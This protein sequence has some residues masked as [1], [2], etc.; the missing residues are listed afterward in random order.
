MNAQQCLMPGGNSKQ[1]QPTQN[2]SKNSSQVLFTSALSGFY[3][4]D[5]EGTT[6]PPVGWQVIDALNPA[7]SWQTSTQTPYNGTKSAFI[8]YDMTN[9]PGEDLLILPKF[10]V[11]TLDSFSFWLALQDT[12]WVPDSTIILVSTTDSALSSFT[13]VIATL[14]EGD[15]YPAV[16]SVY[17]YFSY[18]LSAFAGSDI[19]V[20]I[21]NKNTNGDGVFIDRVEIGTR[22]ALNALPLS[23]DYGT[24]IQTGGMVSPVA[25]IFNDG[26]TT[27]SFPVQMTIQG[28]YSS[29]KNVTNLLPDSI[30]QI[31][32]DPW[33]APGIASLQ[34]ASI[35]TQLA[36]DGFAGDDTLPF[37]INVLEPFTNSGWTSKVP[38]SPIRWG[39]PLASINS[40]DSSSLFLMGGDIGFGVYTNQAR[41]YLANNAWDPLTNLNVKAGYASGASY[42]NKVYVMGG[43]SASTTISNS[44]R[45]YDVATDTWSLGSPMPIPSANYALGIYNDSLFYFI[46]GYNGIIFLN[47]VQIY[48][49]ASDTWTVGTNLPIANAYLNGGISGSK[50]V[51]TGGYGIS[52]LA[53]TYLGDIDPSDPTIITWTTGD[54][55]PAGGCAG[56]AGG[57]SLDESSGLIIFTG[58][59]LNNTLP[60]ISSEYTFAYDVTANQW[61]IGPPKPTP[62]NNLSN[63]VPL[64]FFGNLYM[65]SVGGYGDIGG[66]NVNEWLDMGPY[67]IPT[68]VADN[69]PL[70]F[71]FTSFPNPF[72]NNIDFKFS[73]LQTSMVKVVILDLV[74]QEVEVL[75]NKNLQPG[76]QQL[77]WNASKYTSGIYFCR[78]IV[79]GNEYT[80][81]LVRY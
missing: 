9:A 80:Q 48:N 63:L 21:K 41:K 76:I 37:V 62:A 40:N 59:A 51:V 11:A 66:L 44:N 53:N 26:I 49:A 57:A 10:T 73:L 60:L 50:I 67:V 7:Y 1:Q 46:G 39:V 8:S 13:T 70:S 52:V 72:V 43:Y 61:K 81:K 36:G 54:D 65:V 2:L 17:Q 74:G 27:Q 78:F 12:G 19:Y 20:A 5:F 15:N 68:G 34:S 25:T 32:F 23:I 35:Q 16:R 22:P 55:Y 71:D 58:G 69:N 38:I 24:V 45:I 14:A 33:T 77:Q 31:T 28:G 56:L 47:D 75:C 42:N 18:P 29:V 4:Q 64:L 3:R 6:F 30:Q 79:D